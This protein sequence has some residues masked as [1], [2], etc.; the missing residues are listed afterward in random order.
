MREIVKAGQ[1][2][3]RRVF[4]SVEQARAELADEPFKLELVDWKGGGTGGDV[5]ASEVMEV[6]AGGT[7]QLRQTWTGPA[8]SGVGATCAVARTCRAPG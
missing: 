6:G 4:A 1:V 2:F 8:E 3:R 5:D 7:D